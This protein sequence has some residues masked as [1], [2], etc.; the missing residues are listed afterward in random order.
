VKFAFYGRVSTEDNQSPE[1]SRRWQ[2][3]RSRE[4]IGRHGGEIVESFFDIGLSRSLPWERRPQAKALLDLCG[5]PD[6]GFDAV[7]I[8]E[9]QRAFY[10]DQ[11]SLTFPVFVHYGIQL[12]VPEVGGQ[13]DPGSTAHDMLMGLFGTQAKSE[14]STV[15]T[16]VRGGM[17]AQAAEG[18][19]FLGGRPPY[20]YR[21]A[22]N[23]PHPNPKKAKDGKRLHRLELDPITAPVIG[24]IF[25]E[26]LGGKGLLAIAEGLTRDGI[27]SPSA[28]DR[29]RNRHRT[30]QGWSKSAVK[31]ILENPV[32]TG[33]KVWKK[34][35]RED[36]L[37]DPKNV[38]LGYKQVM[39][40]NK[41]E[42]WIRS[43]QPSHPAIISIQTYQEAQRHR[44]AGNNRPVARQPRKSNRLYVLSG[45]IFC[46]IC[47]RRMQGSA[48][49]KD[50]RYRCCYPAEYALATG[51]ST[52]G[53]STSERTRSC[54]R[55]MRG[56]LSSSTRPP[57][58]TSSTGSWR[59]PTPIRPPPRG[60]RWR[61]GNWPR[62]T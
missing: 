44:A 1:E 14:R 9:P 38:Q 31:A 59:P 62:P 21:L 3:Y 51:S 17:A 20:G 10:D 12:W 5:Q 61:S 6:R 15:K 57:H 36:V 26:Y 28:Y 35:R 7:V 22:D 33:Y 37:L 39:R 16:R 54:R 11:F 49:T 25:T 19:R 18:E 53:R 50:L 46:V 58:Q 41:P 45:L 32:Y 55:L 29:E 2:L 56:W 48:P 27:L 30:G 40:W 42:D 13:V 60:G 43:P 34:Q 24:R 23:G 8:G 4:L 47:G 52:R